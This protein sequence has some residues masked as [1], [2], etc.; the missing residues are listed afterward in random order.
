MKSDI[1]M[2]MGIIVITVLIVIGLMLPPVLK[3]AGAYPLIMSFIKFFFLA[4]IGDIIGYRL[5]VGTWQMPPKIIHKA[6]VWG[7]IGVVIYLMFQIYPNGVKTLQANNILPWENSIFAF[8]LFVSIIINYTFAPTMMSLHRISD[9][10]LNSLKSNHHPKLRD[11]INGINWGNFYQIT[12]FR[13]IPFFWIP[14][15]TI[16]FLLPEAYRIIFAASLGI[17]LGIL[18]RFTDRI[19]KDTISV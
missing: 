15:H 13:T 8:A 6:V 4:S 10:Y 17:I 1:V 7:I 11:I 2:T 19:K 16:T 14:A 3:F 5:Q 9:T 12:L 18:L